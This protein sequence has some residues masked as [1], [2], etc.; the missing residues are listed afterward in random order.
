NG[1]KMLAVTPADPDMIYMLE[2]S[3]RVFNGIYRSVNGGETFQ[4]LSHEQKNY[5]GYST[6]A[7]DDRGQAPRNMDIAVHPERPNEVHIAGILTWVSFDG[8]L[9]F[10]A[11]SDWIPSRAA[12]KNIG[13]CHAD[14]EFLD[15]V[16][17]T[18]YSGSDGGLFKAENT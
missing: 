7:D 12:N 13:Y 17:N 1:P 15:F 14:V 11:T 2:A 18:L 6:N 16:G 8:G 9:T 10:E 3:G 5:F 4:K